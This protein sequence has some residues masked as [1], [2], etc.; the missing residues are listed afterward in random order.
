MPLRRASNLKPVIELDLLNVH[1]PMVD[2]TDDSMIVWG[3]VSEHALSIQR[4]GE[5]QPRQDRTVR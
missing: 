2:V 3:H 5:G 4:Q 1:F